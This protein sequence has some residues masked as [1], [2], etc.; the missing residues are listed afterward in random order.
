MDKKDLR[1]SPHYHLERSNRLYARLL[2]KGFATERKR[3]LIDR[4]LATLYGYT[5][6]ATLVLLSELAR[7]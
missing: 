5:Y 4:P 2:V 1:W 3:P 7:C 6:S